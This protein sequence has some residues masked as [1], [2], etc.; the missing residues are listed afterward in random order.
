MS[1]ALVC[2]LALK[3][4]FDDIIGHTKAK[5]CLRKILSFSRKEVSD[6]YKKFGLTASGGI[7]LHGP[8]GKFYHGFIIVYKE[9]LCRQF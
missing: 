1:K 9:D 5:E 4:S 7:L 6:R 8:P 2:N 3:L